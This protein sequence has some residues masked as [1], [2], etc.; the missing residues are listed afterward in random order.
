[1]I[2]RLFAP[3][4]GLSLCALLLVGCAQSPTQELSDAQVALDSARVA[5]ADRYAADQYQL[6]Q[7][8]LSAAQAEIEAKN[9]DKARTLLAF[10]TETA[11]AAREAV[12]ARKEEAKVEVE[13]LLAQATTALDSVKAQLSAAQTGSTPVEVVSTQ[14]ELSAIEAEL[15]AATQARDS[16]DFATARDQA[17]VVLQKL[18]DLGARLQAPVNPVQ[19]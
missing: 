1:M 5:E 11:N 7:D 9:Y 16:G 2:R 18:N 15:Q 4:A 8:S 6:A 19:S 17:N 3:L 10:V 13:T 12:P 14:D